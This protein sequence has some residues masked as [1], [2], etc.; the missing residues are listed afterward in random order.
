MNLELGGVND[1]EDARQAHGNACQSGAVQSF[2][3]QWPGQHDDQYRAQIRKHQRRHQRHIG[4]T[5]EKTE[6]STCGKQPSPE[7]PCPP[8]PGKRCET[9]LMSHQQEHDGECDRASQEY[10]LR[11][12]IVTG[13][14]FY[15]YIDGRTTEHGSA[16]AQHPQ[17]LLTFSFGVKGDIVL[18]NL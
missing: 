7:L 5:V 8:S 15:G 16:H 9:H 4:K 12:A 2:T 10:D 13:K 14:G 1:E 3:Q 11:G 6:I 17:Q 18:Q